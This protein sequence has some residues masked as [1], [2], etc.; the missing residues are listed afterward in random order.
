MLKIKNDCWYSN[1]SNANANA[2]GNAI[3]VNIIH[4]NTMCGALIVTPLP[5]LCGAS[6]YGVRVQ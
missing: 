2:N 5:I 1:P 6:T 4:G 3:I